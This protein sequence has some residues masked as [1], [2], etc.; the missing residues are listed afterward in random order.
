VRR[1][2]PNAL[3]DV[4][5]DGFVEEAWL[6]RPVALGNEVVLSPFMP[7]GRCTMATRAQPGFDRDLDIAR[8]LNANNGLNLGVYCGVEQPG[9]VG[10][11]DRVTVRT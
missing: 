8:T 1:F 4:D 7:T 11:G 3:L 9:T 6:G 5:G 2:R 10:V